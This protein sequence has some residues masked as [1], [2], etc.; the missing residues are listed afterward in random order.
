M[1]GIGTKTIYAKPGAQIAGKGILGFDN[2]R[3]YHDLA[4][5]HI[6][7]PDQGAQVHGLIV[8]QILGTG[9]VCTT[10]SGYDRV[11]VL[12]NASTTAQSFTV[13]NAAYANASIGTGSGQINLHPVQ[14]AGADATLKTGW[15]FSSTASGGTF[16]VP[17]RTTAVVV[18]FR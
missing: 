14:L 9:G 5:G 15:S 12:Y 18:Q 6:D 8:E 3:L 10:T 7:F 1:A 17:A 16:T 13:A 2:S 4:H 11:V